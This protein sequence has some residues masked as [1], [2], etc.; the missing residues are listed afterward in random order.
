MKT[1]LLQNL[2]GR[3]ST[4]WTTPPAPIYFILRKDYF[5]FCLFIY[6]LCPTGSITQIRKIS[7]QQISPLSRMYNSSLPHPPL[8]FASNTV[9]SALLHRNWFSSKDFLLLRLFWLEFWVASRVQDQLTHLVKSQALEREPGEGQ[10]HFGA[11]AHQ[12]MPGHRQPG[13]R[14][15]TEDCVFFWVLSPE[16]NICNTCCRHWKLQCPLA[17]SEPQYCLEVS[18]HVPHV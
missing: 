17:L 10:C 4:I 2:W 3:C 18:E 15:W 14:P 16:W 6:F 7:I 1:T 13:S 11:F 12:D 5:T 9:H 8:L